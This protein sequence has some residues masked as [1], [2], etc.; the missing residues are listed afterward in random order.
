MSLLDIT[1]AAAPIVVDGR[2]YAPVTNGGALSLPQK[3]GY[4]SVIDVEALDLLFVIR[5][6][7]TT[8]AER[9]DTAPEQITGMEHDPEANRIVLTTSTGARYALDLRGLSVSRLGG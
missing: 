1:E 6:F 2:K 8:P 9:T 5:I 3:T 4:V 7:E